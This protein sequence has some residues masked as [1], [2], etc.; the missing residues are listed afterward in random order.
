[1]SNEGSKLRICLFCDKQRKK[2]NY[3]E[4]PLHECQVE[5][6][7]KDLANILNES[8]NNE[9]NN[10][11]NSLRTYGACYYHNDCKKRFLAKI[12]KREPRETD[13]HKKH[14]FH[15]SAFNEISDFVQERIIDNKECHS[16]R[17]LTDCYNE[18]LE[19]L[20]LKEFNYYDVRFTNQ[21]LLEKLEKSFGDKIEIIQIQKKKKLVAPR[22]GCILND[23]TIC[24]LFEKDLLSRAA[25]ILRK[26]I[27]SIKKKLPEN[28]KVTDII[29]GE[30]YI[31]KELFEFM[32]DLLCGIDNR[33]KKSF[34]NLCRVD[35]FSQDIIYS[36][37]HGKIKTAK[38]LTLGWTLK[39]MSSS[40][41]VVNLLNRAGYCCSYN[42]IEEIETEATFNACSANQISPEDAILG[43][44]YCTGVAFDNYDRFVETRSG[45]DTLHDTNGF[46]YQNIIMTVTQRN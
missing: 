1:M 38:H 34:N 15:S 22:G 26:K 9:I 11:L 10:K 7:Q 4:L 43:P 19:Q 29:K 28:L 21:N 5:N 23:E 31:P 2:L 35:T 45:K 32:R 24:D 42:V 8:S 6:M 12:V 44:N 13:W 46:F 3:R 17:F 18:I 27:L 30:C 20:Y 16:L 41:K 25:M 40:R 37:H 14:Q 36:I 39:S 33:S